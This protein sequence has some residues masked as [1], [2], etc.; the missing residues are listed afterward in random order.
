MQYENQFRTR[1]SISF[2]HRP[3]TI[4]VNKKKLSYLETPEPGHY[5]A[6][7]MTPTDGRPQL[8]KHRTVK[9]SVINRDIRFKPLKSNSPGPMLYDTVDNFN[10]DSRYVLSHRRGEGTRPFDQE[11]K[12][13]NKYWRHWKGNEVPGPGKYEKPSDFGVYGDVNYYKTLSF[14]GW[15]SSH[16]IP[17]IFVHHLIK[18][19]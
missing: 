1:M 10:K 18:Y 7:P 5:E 3:K 4:D 12:F 15:S 19:A 2:T 17:L 13:T 8:S 14:N 11:R 16:N 9:L 6:V